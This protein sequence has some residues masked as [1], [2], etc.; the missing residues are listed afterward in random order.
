[1]S[2]LA[3]AAAALGVPEAIVQRSA[4]ARAKATG[5]SVDEILAAWAG[6]GSV[7]AA[8][9]PEPTPASPAA[10]TAPEPQPAE[11]PQVA[12]AVT[13]PTPVTA[14]PVTAAPAPSEV[15]A[16]EALRYPAVVTVPAAGLLE[17]TVGSL[18]R[19]L[20]AAFLVLPLFGL[21]QLASASSLDCGQGTELSVDRVTGVL[22]NCDGSPFEGRGAPGGAP[23]FVALGG[24][25]FL[26]QVVTAANCSGCHGP[27]GQGGTGPALAGVGTT[28]VS[29]ADHIEWVT[30][31]SSGFQAEGRSTYGDLSKP[32]TANMPSFAASLSAEQIASVVAFERVRFGA[33]DPATVLADCGLVEAAPEDSATTTAGEAGAEGGATTTTTAPET[34]ATTVP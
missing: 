15:N 20:A 17:R 21:L 18:P 8:S 2:D 1:M 3:D 5:T 31:G 13:A 22:E 25:I 12:A 10:E 11:T 32:I 26:G 27:A 33:V 29:C 4:E 16:K 9:S 23:D 14:A 19:W 7:P 24:E 6:G 28:F 34:S 30:K